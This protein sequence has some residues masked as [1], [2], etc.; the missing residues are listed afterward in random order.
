[1]KKAYRLIALLS[2]ITMATQ[3]CAP[4]SGGETLTGGVTDINSTETEKPEYKLPELDYKGGT[5]NFL[6]RGEKFEPT[7]FSHEIYAAGETGDIINDAVYKRNVA[8]E[9]NYNCKI[10]E[11]SDDD[12]VVNVRTSVLAGDGFYDV[13]TE[14]EKILSGFESVSG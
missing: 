10:T 7:N 3:S 1:M 4:K 13:V 12:S 11:T 8:I 2:A 9:E 14:L 6:V 5:V